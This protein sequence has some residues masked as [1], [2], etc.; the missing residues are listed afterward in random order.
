M[1]VGAI[2]VDLAAASLVMSIESWVEEVQGRHVGGGTIDQ[3]EDVPFA[4]LRPAGALPY[5]DTKSPVRRPD[6]LLLPAQVLPQAYL[7]LENHEMARF[8]GEA[9]PTFKTGRG[10]AA[11]RTVL[12]RDDVE[13]TVAGHLR[14][15]GGVGVSLELVVRARASFDVPC[16]GVCSSARRAVEVVPPDEGVAWYFWRHGD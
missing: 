2:E 7:G 8:A 15:C 13:L 14:V 5:V 12:A 10:P 3:F 11:C 16:V 9:V 6:A 4:A 1:E